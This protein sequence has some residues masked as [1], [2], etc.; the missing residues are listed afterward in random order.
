MQNELEY[1]DNELHELYEKYKYKSWVAYLYL[2]G[3]SDFALQRFYI[4][5]KISLQIGIIFCFI[6]LTSLILYSL[7]REKGFIVFSDVTEW[8]LIL[9]DL[10][11]IPRLVKNMNDELLNNIKQLRNIKFQARQ[12]IW[13]YFAPVALILRVIIGLYLIETYKH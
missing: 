5:S 4:G 2:I 11:Y 3:Y 7:S 6:K 1:Q 8:G 13:N 12:T 9:F 10:F